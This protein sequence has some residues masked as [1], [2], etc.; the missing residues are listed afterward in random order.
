MKCPKCNN[1][2]F[3]PIITR[4]KD[5]VWNNKNVTITED[6]YICI[7]CG[8]EVGTIET[9]SNIQDQLCKKFI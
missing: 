4:D 1:H 7:K 9:A 3:I 2:K 6:C 8:L 5:I